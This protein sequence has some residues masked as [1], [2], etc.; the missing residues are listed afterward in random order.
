M[1]DGWKHGANPLIKA[2]AVAHES[3]TKAYADL[4]VARAALTTIGGWDAPPWD[5]TAA[6]A[7]R[8]VATEALAKMETEE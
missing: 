4:D 3:L 6:P 1:D 2:L 8:S 5:S 7:M